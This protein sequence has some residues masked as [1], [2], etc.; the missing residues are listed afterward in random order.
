LLDAVAEGGSG[1]SVLE[2]EGGRP[3]NRRS[4]ELSPE[5]DKSDQADLRGGAR[6]HRWGG[7]LIKASSLKKIHGTMKRKYEVYI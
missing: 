7:Q 3:T 1:L 5:G 2:R 6:I 4:W